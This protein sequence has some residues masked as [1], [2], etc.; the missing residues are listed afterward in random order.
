MSSEANNVKQSRVVP[1]N[2]DD[3][4]DVLL[5]KKFRRFRLRDMERDVL[6]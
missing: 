6:F 2:S 4:L 3:L 1:L 5:G